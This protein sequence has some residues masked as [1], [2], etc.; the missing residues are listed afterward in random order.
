MSHKHF[1]INERNKLEVLLKENYKIARIAEILEKDKTTIYREIKRVKG[2]YC[3]EKAQINA[4]NKGCKKGRNYKITSELKNLIESK[5]CERWSPE[6]IVGPE[7]KGKLSFKTIYN[8]LYKDFFDVSLDKGKAAKTKE[9]RGKFNIG[10]SISERPEEVKKKK[11]L[12]I[13]SWIP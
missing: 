6:Q 5:L 2:E 8:W 10:K 7:L 11:F 13:G 12:N 1:T 4:N 9:K 3:A